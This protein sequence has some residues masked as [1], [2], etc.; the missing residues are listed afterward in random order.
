MLYFFAQNVRPVWL[1]SRQ[2]HKN[3]VNIN[4]DN[5]VQKRESEKYYM[6]QHRNHREGHFSIHCFVVLGFAVATAK[7]FRR[8]SSDTEGS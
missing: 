2:R 8:G 4:P 6:E 3:D 1:H 7:A 5:S